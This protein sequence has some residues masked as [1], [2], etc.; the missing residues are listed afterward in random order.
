MNKTNYKIRTWIDRC[1]RLYTIMIALM[2]F[3]LMTN[4]VDAIT[5][6]GATSIPAVPTLPYV[7][8]LTCG[9]DDITSANSTTCGSGNYKGGQEAVFVWTP[10]SSYT[11]VSIAYAGVSWTGIFLYNGCPT[12]GGTCVGNI[13][14]S[15]TSKTLS[16]MSVT[17]GNT[18]YIVID[19]WPTPNSPCPGTITLNGTIVPGCSGTPTS[20]SITAPSLAC[21]GTA[22]NMTLTGAT[23]GT[24]IVYQWQSGS[25]GSGPWTNVGTNSASYSATQTSTTFYQVVV[26]CTLSGQSSTTAAVSVGIDTQLNCYCASVHTSGCSGDA[27]VSATLNTLSNT[28]G[29]TCPANP[30]YTYYSPGV[31]QTTLYQGSSYSLVM[32]FGTDGNQYAGAWIDYDNNGTLDAGENIGLTGNAGASG[33]ATINFTVPPTATTA[34]TRLRLIG[35]N[36]SPVTAVQACGASSSTWGETEDYDITIATPPACS[37]S[38][39]TGTAN[40]SATTVCP[41]GTTTL[42]VSGIGSETGYTYQWYDGAYNP[43]P[44]A[45]TSTYIATPTQTETYRCLVTC[46]NSGGNTFTSDVVVNFDASANA[47]TISGPS[48]GSTFSNLAYS[49][50]AYL[51]NLQWQ[52]ATALAGPYSD[53]PSATL[54]NVSLVSNAAGTFYVRLRAASATC[55]TYSNVITIVVTIPNDN[56]CNATAIS[57]GN[58][59]PYTNIGAT[60]E[61]GEVSPPLIGCAVQNGWCSGGNTA[62]NSVW[63]SFT[64]P[65]SGRVSIRL[66][67]TLTLFDSQFALYS[68]TN[69][70]DFG[71][72]TMIA[73][74]DDSLNSPYNSYIAPKCLIPGATYYLKVDGYQTTTNGN[75]GILLTEETS[76]LPSAA[77]SG[78][79]AICNGNSANLSISFTGASSWTYSVNGG[80]PVTT[81]S[82]PETVTV[83][84]SST[85]AYTVTSISDAN[86]PSGTSSGTANVTV[87]SA[88]PVNGVQILTWPTSACQGNTVVITTNTVIGATGYTWSVDAGTLVD[89]NPGPYTTASPTATLTLGAVPANGSGWEVC[90]SASNACGVTNTNC[91][92]IRGALSTPA[93]IVGSSYACPSSA[94][95]YSTGVV[96]GASGY[97][98][99]ITGD[100]SVTGTSTTGSVTFGP[101]FTTGTLCVRAVLPCGYQSAQRCMSITNS[102]GFLGTISG[103]FSVCPGQNGVVY[104]VSPVANAA[105][106]AWTVPANIS[107]VSGQGTNSITVNVGAGFNVG[108]ICLTA[109][110]NCGVVSAPRCKTVAS[111][112]PVTPGNIT[113]AATGICGATI[114]HS[115]PAVAG[116]T[117]YTW[118][119]PSGATIVNG[120]NTNSVDV[121]YSGSF[122]TGQLC[123]TANNA[124][125]SSTAR[126]INVK[127]A[128][129]NPGVIAG[130]TTVCAAEQ[131]LS[132]SVAA[133]FGASNYNWSLPA[134]AVIVAGANTNSIVVDWG[135]ASGSV[136]VTT[137]NGCGISGTRTLS[138]LINCKVSGSELP[139]AVVSAYPNPVSTKLNVDVQ[140]TTAGTYTLELSDLTGRI[141]LNDMIQASEGMNSVNLNVA[142]LSKGVYM[143]SVKNAE[144]FAKQI[145]IAVE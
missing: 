93:V 37:G 113:G 35:G 142:E 88:P 96:P 3:T 54:D 43:I 97:E 42:S 125:G 110:S 61:V 65:P 17:A 74:N 131:G 23:S 115:V 112:K 138:V 25:S 135:N 32:T 62:V 13:T 28:T 20:G 95:S 101:A 27:I 2:L 100:A 109:T 36:D 98:W 107:I 92:N 89:G 1:S 144:G 31:S 133:V 75:W 24:G 85:T 119:A 118:T 44:G 145:R 39:A 71:T 84:P 33:T 116:A 139:G 51:G 127:G 103:T 15:S 106:Y 140:V 56:A 29:A 40:A 11:G 137:S 123:V 130:P 26:T 8:A 117:S 99:S 14:S 76:V 79:Q 60:D 10:T 50:N 64:A 141:V 18:Y 134:G 6:G 53:V 91:R 136:T 5:C 52:S 46:S 16:G 121:S 4:R 111:Q 19:T 82:N 129:G 72:Y 38:P 108:N 94:G 120:Q 114:T 104:S 12:S 83:N 78:T 80:A 21:S 55:T 105:S 58:S 9:A 45:N 86:C 90:V 67:P 143:L 73:A 87:D 49:T 22:F 30:A 57:T 102:V 48:S 128:P 132:Y 126:C 77:I 69:C 122:T 124:C 59:G 70:A 66:N 63:F 7:A 81:S 47:G 68:A 41:G 34:L